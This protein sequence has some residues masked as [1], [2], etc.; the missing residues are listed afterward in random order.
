LKL[1]QLILLPEVTFLDMKTSLQCLFIFACLQGLMAQNV[2][3]N[4]DGS[5]PDNSAMLDV[6]ASDRGLLLPRVSL[7]NVTS[8]SPVTSPAT[9]LLV[10]NTNA[11]VTGG[12]G[13]GFYYWDGSQW[14]KLDAGN[15]GDWRLTGNAGTS[16][17][18]NFLGT[19][20]ATDLSIRTNST[21]RIRVS[22]SGTVRLNNYTTNN[23][24]KT[25]GGDGT[26]TVGAVNLASSEVTGLL[27]IANGGTNS[28]ATPTAGG[29]AYG[30]GTAYAFTPAG[31]TGNLL[32]SNGTSAPSWTDPNTLFWRVN[33]NS[34]RTPSSSN[35]GSAVN[36]NFIG[37]TDD[38]DFVVARN[39]L[40]AF[41][42][43]D[44]GGSPVVT[45]NSGA[46]GYAVG[47]IGSL[48]TIMTIGGAQNTSGVN[49][50]IVLIMDRNTSNDAPDNILGGI[51]LGEP[52]SANRAGQTRIE[53]RRSIMAASSGATD[54]PSD[55]VFYTTPDGT[56]TARDW[57][58]LSHD[59]SLVLGEND[60]K[61][62]YGPGRLRGTWATGTDA[63]GQNLTID[64]GNG[65]GTGGSGNLVFR[66]A[67]PGASGTTPNT[68]TERMR[69][70]NLGRVGIG[71][72]SPGHVLHVAESADDGSVAGIQVDESNSGQALVINESGNGTGILINA[73]DNGAGIQSTVSGA[74]TA[75][76]VGHLFYD[77]R[78][79]TTASIGKIG[80]DIQSTGTWSGTGASNN[81]LNVVASGGTTN[82]GINVNVSGGTSYAGLFNGGNVGIG[83]STPATRL[84]V[85]GGTSAA[86]TRMVTLRS[87]FTAD[88]TGTAIALINSTSPTSNVGAELAAIT[89]NSSSG[90]SQLVFRTHGGGGSFGGLLE[91]MRLTNQ[92]FLG[93]GTNDPLN[94]LHVDNSAVGATS[95]RL[96]RTATQFDNRL[97]FGD[98][99][100]V[101]V[102]EQNA[103]DRLYL[104]G[105]TMTIDING[106]T[107]GAN[108][109]VLTSNGTTV[110]WQ[111]P[112]PI[113]A[114]IA[115]VNHLPGTPALPPGWV[116]CNGGTVSDPE[117]PI[118]GQ[119]IPNL[120]N[121]PSGTFGTPSGG[122]YLRG[123]TGTTG[124]TQS[125]RAPDFQIEQ[126]ANSQGTQ[127]GTVNNDGATS[128]Y[129]PWL[130]NYYLDDSLRWRYVNGEVR[131]VTYTVRWIM[132]IK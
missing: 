96:G 119:P 102:G 88:N 54:L 115:W 117:S 7:T 59:G 41:R 125:D 79:S 118:N 14:V 86:E 99:S 100:F 110:S 1:D 107:G 124:T 38:N 4:A 130:R 95:A 80:V 23:V 56:N 61:V 25:S 131:P 103:D 97:F 30:T 39:N 132:R 32:V 53:G 57:M 2:G 84:D 112:V 77:T 40:E 76:S 104:R 51:A 87:N 113:G 33:G 116:E 5:S 12:N 58:R 15:S 31:S 122:Y 65:T 89:T 62:G 21:E 75:G 90:A 42:V 94:Q 44:V 20:D 129:S 6:K 10:F 126:S 50:P 81:A 19:T 17:A 37:T 121:I 92:G 45:F 70:T 109:R 106:N 114:I 127:S 22:S 29:I 46:G 82:V 9:G 98:G 27:P 3:I 8:A 28:T 101:Y 120:N 35:I 34:G 64:A 85:V 24:V 69:I 26:L 55:L 83:T 49:N 91:R 16:P 123:T 67:P 18:S 93:I 52:G 60:N 128:N 63:V 13:T 66:T 105:S 74:V 108:G 36:N 68:M 111:P 78:T 72:S 73:A 71:T 48:N 11:S 43:R 47:S